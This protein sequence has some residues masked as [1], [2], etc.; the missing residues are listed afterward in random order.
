MV[1]ASNRRVVFGQSHPS[2]VLLISILSL[3]AVGVYD[4][5]PG[6]C[7]IKHISVFRV[8][9]YHQVVWDEI[10]A[11]PPATG[12]TTPALTHDVI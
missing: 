3:F 4:V 5:N 11:T 7:R 2:E 9:P 6:Y 12:A 8:S 10:V 1:N